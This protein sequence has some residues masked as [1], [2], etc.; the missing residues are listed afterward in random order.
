MKAVKRLFDLALDHQI[1]VLAIAQA[2]ND[3]A[4]KARMPRKSD[5]ADCTGI[6]RQAHVVLGLH[7]PGYYD[8]GKPQDEAL[9]AVDKCRV[10]VLGTVKVG[11]NGPLT[12]FFDRGFGGARRRRAPGQSGY[13]Q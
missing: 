9:I 10:G 4:D 1:A 3:C 8:P 6:G 13:V 12:E 11:W 7:R 2:K 5:L